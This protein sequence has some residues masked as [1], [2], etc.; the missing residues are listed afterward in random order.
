[1]VKEARPICAL[2]NLYGMG[3]YVE[4]VHGPMWRTPVGPPRILPTNK[5]SENLQLLRETTRFHLG[6]KRDDEAE[7]GDW[8]RQWCKDELS[9]F[10]GL[11]ARENGCV[12]YDAFM[13]AAIADA[14]RVTGGAAGRDGVFRQWLRVAVPWM[15][16]FAHGRLIAPVGQRNQQH[17][18]EVQEA[19]ILNSVPLKK[20]FKQQRFWPAA[21]A[22]LGSLGLFSLNE[23]KQ[24]NDVANGK[25]PLPWMYV[26]TKTRNRFMF[27]RWKHGGA[28]A[29]LRDQGEVLVGYGSPRYAECWN[30][31]GHSYWLEPDE[32]RHA[33]KRTCE[34]WTVND[35][36]RCTVTAEATGEK[37]SIFLPTKDLGPLVYTAICGPSG[38]TVTPA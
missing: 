11:F 23:A 30:E 10:T 3:P 31:E 25:T 35:G 17:D 18:P 38:M 7:P 21:V 29:M 22:N 9:G 14:Y 13:V 19:Q 32:K 12:A 6:E 34:A 5:S 2:L 36:W 24:L 16:M 20:V 8:L 33:I 4:A 37:Q 15:T 27:W 28:I 1:M 26:H